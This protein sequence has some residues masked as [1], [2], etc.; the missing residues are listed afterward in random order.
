MIKMNYTLKKYTFL[1]AAAVLIFSAAYPS[2]LIN[3]TIR[4]NTNGDDYAPS[5]TEDGTTAVFNSKMPEERSHNIFICK[6]KNG[7][8]G[9]PYPIFEINSDSNDETPFISADGKTILFAS[10]RPGGFTPPMTSDGKKRITF[11]IYIS[12]LVNGRWTAPE[13][14]KGTVNTSMNERAPGLSIDG[15][16][17]FFTRWPYNNMSKS[18]VYSA[19]LDDG[20]FTDVKELPGSIN[21]GNFEIGFRPSYKSGRYYFASRKPGGSGGWDIYYTT[22]TSKGFTTPVNAGGEI[23]TPYDD[24]YYSESKFNSILSSDRGGGLGMFDLYSSLPAEKSS[25][26]NLKNDFKGN[27]SSILHI[28]IRDKKSGKL[29]KKTPFKIILMGEREKESAVLRK[30]EV[31]SGRTGILTLYPKDDVDSVVIEPASKYYNGCSVKIRINQGQSQ[32]ITLYMDRRSS[33]NNSSCIDSEIKPPAE[34]RSDGR[35]DLPVLKVI[36]FKFDSSSIPAE[37]IPP[38][39]SLVEF[40]R[41]NPEY[42]LYISGYSDPAGSSRINDKLSMK[43]AKNVADFIKTLEITEDRITVEWFGEKKSSSGKRGPRYYNLDRKVELKL[44]K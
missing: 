21:T 24:M 35:T 44:E 10:D 9:D 6:N 15:K 13:I 26:I 42:N 22:A 38:L 14:L 1:I 20:G 3:L 36:Y 34:N 32:K 11:D 40:M 27:T 28:T 17:L 31:K 4:I 37:Y 30:T 18:K 16:T 33:S 41:L 8:W 7:L 39:H 23:N 25:A 5:L 43:R 12:R 2:S 19:K 29:L